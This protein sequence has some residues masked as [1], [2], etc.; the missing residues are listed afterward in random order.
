MTSHDKMHVS[1]N[2]LDMIDDGSVTECAEYL[3]DP[4]FGFEP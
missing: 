2:E 4:T 1:S 3:V